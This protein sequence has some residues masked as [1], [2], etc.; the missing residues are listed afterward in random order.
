MKRT[1]SLFSIGLLALVSLLGLGCKLL[2]KDEGKFYT[3]EIVASPDLAEKTATID[4]IG[5][6]GANKQDWESIKPEIYWAGDNSTRKELLRDKR[7]ITRSLGV[8]TTNRYLLSLA[9]PDV[10]QIWEEE[11]KPAK[12]TELLLMVQTSEANR[13][14]IPLR[15]GEVQQLYGLKPKAFRIYLKDSGFIEVKA[16]PD[17]PKE[18]DKSD[19]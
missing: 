8:W 13:K 19:K 18:P 5:I 11:W 9:A 16:L 17:L 12:I 3:L 15:P 1:I 6:S 4:I 7:C 14:F 2:S 10:K